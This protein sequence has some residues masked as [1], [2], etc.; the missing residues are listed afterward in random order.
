MSRHEIQGLDPRDKVTVGWDH[1]LLTYF[2]QVHRD[3]V[4][5]DDN[6]IH[7]VGTSLRELYEIDDLARAMRRYAVIPT[8]LRGTLYGDKDE[9]R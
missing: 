1:P 4:E 5:E 2:G 9:G 6:P 7:W 3:G 8:E